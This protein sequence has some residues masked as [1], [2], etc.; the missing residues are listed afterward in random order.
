MLIDDLRLLISLLS[1]LSLSAISD[2]ML[3]S[4]TDI[5]KA[6]NQQIVEEQQQGVTIT[7]DVLEQIDQIQ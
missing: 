7:Q 1:L 6:Y 3:P 4:L 5:L 2:I